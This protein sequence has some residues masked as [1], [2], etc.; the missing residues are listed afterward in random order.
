M[1]RNYS[2]LLRRVSNTHLGDL[3][4]SSLFLLDGQKCCESA[5]HCS[6]SA[7]FSEPTDNTVG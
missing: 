2:I 5:T 1:K 3:S 6:D 4:F 7:K